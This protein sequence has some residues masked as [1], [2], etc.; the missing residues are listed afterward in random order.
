MVLDTVVDAGA[1]SKKAWHETSCGVQDARKQAGYRIDD[2]IDISFVA[3]PEVVA[4][5]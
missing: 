1:D 2:T 3:D 5:D 4:S